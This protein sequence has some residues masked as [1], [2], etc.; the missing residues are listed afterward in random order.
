MKE[1]DRFILD[2]K[3]LGINGEGIGFYNKLA[4]FVKDAIPGEGIEVEVTKVLPNMAYAKALTIKN[5]SNARVLP[6][7]PYYSR[8]GACQVMHIDYQKMGEFKRDAVIEAIKRYTKI[9][10]KSFEI[11]QT[12]LAQEPYHYRNKATLVVRKDKGMNAISMIEEGTNRSFAVDSC[13]VQDELIN[14]INQKIIELSN[15]LK[16]KTLGDDNYSWRYLVTR[17]TKTTRESLVC[18]VVYKYDDEIKNF[19]K[20]ILESKICD[21]LY[22]NINNDSKTHEIFGTDTIHIGGKNSVIEMIGKYK[23]NIYPTTFFQLNTKQTEVLY[24]RVK[25]AAKL[26]H[27]ERVLD[28]YCGVGTIASYLAN[29]S[30]EVIG[31]EYNKESIV[32]AKENLKLNKI[33]NISFYQGDTAKLL[34]ELIKKDINF[35]VAVFDPPRT[36]LGKDIIDTLLKTNI[37]RIVYVSCNPATLAKDLALL[38]EKYNIRYIEP[39]DMFPNTSHVE[40]VTLL[41]L[42]K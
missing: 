18:L 10:P 34:L 11:K 17:V 38:T 35:D 24:E 12:I 33:K 23:F 14:K 16:I 8:C 40:S 9:N 25:K 29:V 42:K 4:I 27:Q 6:E 5:K 28:A 39:I 2:I 7:C 3:R 26:T 1:K 32:A 30:K 19:A 37:K 22:I 15:E 21:S 31:I 41:D 36:G 13:L 20:K